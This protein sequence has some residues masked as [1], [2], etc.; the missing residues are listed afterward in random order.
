MPIRIPFR[1]RIADA[2]KGYRREDFLAD[3]GAGVTVGLVALPPAM[4][5]A[6]ASAV[7]PEQGI[8]TA[9]VG[10]LAVS[11]LGGSRVQIAGPAG[12]FVAM[13]YGI[14]EKYVIANLLIATMMAGCLLLAMGA[15]RIGT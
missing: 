4:A 15:F 13:L 1:P 6:P 7:R 8:G 14:A 5:F 2:L 12:A 3:A 10:G 9:I 11:L